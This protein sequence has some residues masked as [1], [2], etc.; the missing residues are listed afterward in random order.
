MRRTTKISILCLEGIIENISYERYAYESVD[1]KIAYLR[2]N[3]K[4][5]LKNLCI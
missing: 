3:L 5:R 1:D 2:L 4:K